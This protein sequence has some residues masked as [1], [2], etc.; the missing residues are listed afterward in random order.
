[1]ISDETRLFIR[2]LP[3][4]LSIKE[5]AGFFSISRL[6]AYRMVYR[7]KIEAYKDDKGDWCILRC[8]VEKFCSKNGNL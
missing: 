1:M 5:L 7:K 6:T 8:D 3:A 2:A 4:I